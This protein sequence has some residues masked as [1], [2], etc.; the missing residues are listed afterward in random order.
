MFPSFFAIIFISFKQ[1]P[2]VILFCCSV[3]ITE[4]KVFLYFL[5]LSTET[6]SYPDF[7]GL[8]YKACF[9]PNGSL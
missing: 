4:V 2:V 5:Y 7:I 3:L 1:A 8:E 6:L 9:F